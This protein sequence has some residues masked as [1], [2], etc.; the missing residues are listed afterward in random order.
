MDKKQLKKK[1][2]KI[3]KNFIKERD[4]YTCQRCEKRVEGTDCHA[5]HVIP[6]SLDGWLAHDSLNMKVLC[7]KCHIDFWH[8]YP[9]QAKEWFEK[10]FPLRAA[11]L[12]SQH[13]ENRTRGPIP[14]SYYEN[15]IDRIKFLSN[16]RDNQSLL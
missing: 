3:A 16:V 14:A 7:R 9:L 11:Y 6:V 15:E 12:D 1:L 10:K 5:S 8:A 2:E 4:N 13:N